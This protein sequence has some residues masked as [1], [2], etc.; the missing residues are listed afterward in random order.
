MVTLKELATK[1]E[2]VKI[3]DSK[4]DSL[5]GPNVRTPSLIINQIYLSKSWKPTIEGSDNIWRVVKFIGSGRQEEGSEQIELFESNPRIK[6]MKEGDYYFFQCVKDS[7]FVVFNAFQADDCLVYG[8]PPIRL[9]FFEVNGITVQTKPSSKPSEKVAKP[10]KVAKD[11]PAASKRGRKN[12]NNLEA[13]FSASEVEQI[14]TDQT[15]NEATPVSEQELPEAVEDNSQRPEEE[16]TVAETQAVEHADEIS[17][18]SVKTS[19]E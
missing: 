6:D 19:K 13:E 4:A 1:V 8:V 11:K 18:E 9:T 7:D 14:H 2:T 5:R 10:A 12:K 15:N 17:T 3:S 16:L